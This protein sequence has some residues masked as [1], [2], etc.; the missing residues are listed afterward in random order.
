MKITNKYYLK[1]FDFYFDL[2]IYLINFIVINY[3]FYNVSPDMM[4][5]YNVMSINT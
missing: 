5:N 2:R 1:L 3:G 4:N